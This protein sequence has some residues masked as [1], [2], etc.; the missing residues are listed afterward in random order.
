[1]GK[2]ATEREA[3]RARTHGLSRRE[4]LLRRADY[5]ATYRARRSAADD[6]LVV[7]VRP[8]GLPF[9]RIGLSVSGKWGKSVRRNRFRRLCREAFRL[10]KAELPVGL[11]L[12]VIPRRGIDMTLEEV[13]KSLVVLAR[14]AVA[15]KSE[16]K[17]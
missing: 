8:N 9:S 2:K 5:E 15:K 12:V 13:A 17:K 7:C 10:H 16:P 11:D 4:R 1:M 6:R 14:K 3:T